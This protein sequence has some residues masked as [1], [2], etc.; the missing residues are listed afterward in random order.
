MIESLPARGPKCRTH[1][2]KNRR[3]AQCSADRF[4]HVGG[5]VTWARMAK[6]KPASDTLLAAATAAVIAAGRAGCPL[7]GNPDQTARFARVN[8]RGMHDD[9]STRIVGGD[10][11]LCR[12]R[13]MV[14]SVRIPHGVA[15]VQTGSPAHAFPRAIF[16]TLLPF[17]LLSDPR[18]G[19]RERV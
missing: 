16:V 3:F 6:Q 14:G 11:H 2:L 13:Q 10:C 4:R 15:G 5:E 17:S 8:G 12:A 7:A 1:G 9:R 18:S 19:S